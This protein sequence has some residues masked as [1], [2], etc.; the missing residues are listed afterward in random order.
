MA[1]SVNDVVKALVAPADFQI[2]RVGKAAFE[3]GQL[4]NQRFGRQYQPDMP[5]VADDEGAMGAR[6][7]GLRGG[8]E[9]VRLGGAI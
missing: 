2:A 1:C 5:A 6:A 8:G 3:F 4:R 7:F 9:G